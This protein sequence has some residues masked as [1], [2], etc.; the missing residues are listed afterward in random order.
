ML[1]SKSDLGRR[2]RPASR[3]W[4]YQSAQ[5]VDNGTSNWMTAP[6]PPPPPPSADDII[7]T[8]AYSIDHMNMSYEDMNTVRATGQGDAG[9]GGGRK[10]SVARR[11]QREICCCRC[12][13]EICR[14]AG[15]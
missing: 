9:R 8:S 6:P 7:P 1:C 3:H 12:V 2:P 15:D 4:E 5:E 14:D 13:G 11:V 10:G